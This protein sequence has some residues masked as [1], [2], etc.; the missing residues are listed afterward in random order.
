MEN[1][2]ANVYKKKCTLCDQIFRTKS[3]ALSHIRMKHGQITYQMGKS[4]A[5]LD[6][7]LLPIENQIV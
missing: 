2:R 3:A 1:K 7:I 4:N 6:T 5:P